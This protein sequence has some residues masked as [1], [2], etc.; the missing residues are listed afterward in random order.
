[1]FVSE[2]H[3]Q[4]YWFHRCY[5][6]SNA[7]SCKIDTTWFPKGHPILYKIYTWWE[8]S[9]NT[10]FDKLS[11]DGI[12]NNSTRVAEMSLLNTWNQQSAFIKR[13]VSVSLRCDASSLSNGQC[14]RDRGQAE[15]K[16]L[17]FWVRLWRIC[18]C[19]FRQYHCLSIV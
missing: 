7:Y 5:I 4:V 8:E 1:M 3:H 14:R 6:I 18:F 11:Q 12:I 10:K 9:V 2:V 17:G 15:K 19:L 16:L 13:K